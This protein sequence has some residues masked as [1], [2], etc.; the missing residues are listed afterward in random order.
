MTSGDKTTL[1]EGEGGS[2]ITHSA[3]LISTASLSASPG[4]SNFTVVLGEARM[5]EFFGWTLVL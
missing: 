5:T 3:G 1:R 4:S 2:G